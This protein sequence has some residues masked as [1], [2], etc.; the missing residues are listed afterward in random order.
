[1]FTFHTEY[2]FSIVSE[3]Q[4]FLFDWIRWSLSYPKV[5]IYGGP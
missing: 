4:I 5:R 3:G 2:F 1:L